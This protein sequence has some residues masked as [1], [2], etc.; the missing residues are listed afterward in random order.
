M[1][2]DLNDIRSLIALLG[3]ALFLGLMAWTWWPTRRRA[4]DAAARLPFLG[5]DGG[6]VPHA[7]RDDMGR[8]TGA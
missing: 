3:L 4:H 7:P 8:R 5:E 1:H 6:T 2:M